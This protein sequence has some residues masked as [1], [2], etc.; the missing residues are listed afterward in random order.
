MLQNCS[1]FTQSSAITNYYVI[2]TVTWRQFMQATQI[3]IS[4]Y[5]EKLNNIRN[6][7]DALLRVDRKQ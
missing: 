7:L 5:R 2:R 3:F 4:N 6:Q 1:C